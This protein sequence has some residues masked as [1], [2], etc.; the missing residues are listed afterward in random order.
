M[1][2]DSV[3]FSSLP[4]ELVQLILQ[5]L[6][7][8]IA[9]EES[10]HFHRNHQGYNRYLAELS[11]LILVSKLFHKLVIPYLYREIRL[12]RHF[13]YASSAQTPDALRREDRDLDDPH[14]NVDISALFLAKQL[15]MY[16]EQAAFV[17]KIHLD[18]VVRLK[19]KAAIDCQA[20]TTIL[21]QCKD[22]IEELAIAVNHCDGTVRTYRMTPRRTRM[23]TV[24]T[25][26]VLKQFAFARM[27]K[28]KHLI[29]EF[30]QIRQLDWILW[31]QLHS[32]EEVTLLVDNLFDLDCMHEPPRG[33]NM[34]QNAMFQGLSR[35]PKNV[36]KLTLGF[37]Y[38]FDEIN[39]A[40]MARSVHEFEIE[41]RDGA[42]EYLHATLSR[43]QK[44]GYLDHLEELHL[45]WT[46]TPDYV[47]RCEQCLG[48][49]RRP[50]YPLPKL[51]IA[52]EF[53]QFCQ[54]PLADLV[55][56]RNQAGASQPST[57]LR[58]R[59]SEV[60]VPPAYRPFSEGE[61][62]M[63]CLEVLWKCL[64]YDRNEEVNAEDVEGEVAQ[65]E[66][67]PNESDYEE[68]FDSE[69]TDEDSGWQSDAAPTPPAED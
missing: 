11:K 21:Q 5:H 65:M 4:V 44:E 24:G 16:P 64:V 40:E 34:K 53:E 18:P 14:K 6:V 25:H 23:D 45:V 27:P 55:E 8:S 38:A 61:E 13:G 10:I 41:E 46:H 56:F 47:H 19:G 62:A 36:K 42:I 39:L 1:G 35:L 3:Q 52:S 15:Q 60:V 20:Y 51:R 54:A 30:M 33:I 31:D 69:W 59:M 7:T 32:L 22:T 66:P 49:D 26:L 67:C 2:S 68:E 43:A 37:V 57:K 17:K 48:R 12:P 63:C 58:I 29:L 9:P 28:L 50:T